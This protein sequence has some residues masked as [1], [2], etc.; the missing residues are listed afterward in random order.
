MEAQLARLLREDES[1]A[2]GRLPA[3]M[4][5]DQET[6]VVTA[7]AAEIVAADPS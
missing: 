1:F 4:T 6:R 3:G 5:T 7:V 2:A